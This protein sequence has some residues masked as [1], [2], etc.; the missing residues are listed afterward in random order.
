[1]YR[2]VAVQFGQPGR[3]NGCTGLANVFF[4]EEE[5]RARR[6]A[7]LLAMTSQPRSLP[8]PERLRASFRFVLLARF[9]FVL[10]A[11]SRF[12]LDRVS[13]AKT[14]DHGKTTRPNRWIQ[15]S[16]ETTAESTP[17]S[18]ALSGAF[19]P[20]EV[21][22]QNGCVDSAVVMRQFLPSNT[23][24]PGSGGA[25]RHRRLNQ[26]RIRGAIALVDRGS[27]SH[28]G[29]IPSRRSTLHLHALAIDAFAVTRE[30]VP[31]LRS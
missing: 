20:C 17:V 9:R 25:V 23:T 16:W 2:H 21:T 30:N 14:I 15:G 6:L 28:R 18:S 13:N 5:L 1:M 22:I 7:V 31:W 12:V 19:P 24:S 11:R 26:R 3:A 10:L 8:R 4:A 27:G 29:N